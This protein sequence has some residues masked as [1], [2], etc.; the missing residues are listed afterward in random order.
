MGQKKEMACYLS[1]KVV[2][3]SHILIWTLI[4]SAWPGCIIL[5][6]INWEVLEP[7]HIAMQHSQ[8][9]METLNNC[10]EELLDFNPHD[11]PG[12]WV[13]IIP[14]FLRIR[15]L[16]LRGPSP[17]IRTYTG[18]VE[19]RFGTQVCL[20]QHLGIFKAG[21]YSIFLNCNIYSNKS[22]WGG[23]LE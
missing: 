13:L 4:S 23:C 10:R 1:N 7:D 18:S 14:T 15:K 11:N 16:L 8:I 22:S 20:M 3:N 19:T 5:K 17:C 12:R 21:L 6:S 9:C 2:Y